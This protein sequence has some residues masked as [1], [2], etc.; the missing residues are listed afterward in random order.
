M[1]E[2]EKYHDT[3]LNAPECAVFQKLEEILGKPIP[4]VTQLKSQPESHSFGFVAGDGYAT[5]LGLQGQKLSVLPECIGN[6]VSLQY[7]GLSSNEISSLPQSMGQLKLL[8]KLELQEN[9]LISLPMSI[10]ELTSLRE[11]NL[12][13]NKLSSL[14]DSIGSL[15]SLKMLALENNQLLSLPET[16]GN[17]SSLKTL[18][19]SR[20]H[21]PSLPN[22]IGQLSSLE[23]LTLANNPLKILPDSLGKLQFLLTLDLRETLLSQLGFLPEKITQ[24]IEAIIERKIKMGQV[25]WCDYFYPGL[26]NVCIYICNYLKNLEKEGMED[27]Y[28][29]LAKILGM[30]WT[31]FMAEVHSWVER[32]HVQLDTSDTITFGKDTDWP[33]LQRVLEQIVFM[34]VQDRQTTEWGQKE[35][36]EGGK[37]KKVYDQTKKVNEPLALPLPRLELEALA[38]LEQVYGF[39]IPIVP[40]LK[41]GIDG[42]AVAGGCVIAISLAHAKLTTL[43][44]TFSNFTHL[45]TLNLSNSPFKIF[46]GTICQLKSLQDLILM[47]CGL[48]SLPEGIGNLKSLQTLELGVNN[49]ETLPVAIGQLGTLQYIDL[50]QNKFTSFPEAITR[51]SSLTRLHLG[52]N[53]LR[54]LPAS[55]ESL[56]SLLELDLYDNSFT[57]FPEIVIRLKSLRSLGI[58]GILFTDNP[59]ISPFVSK[60]EK[61]GVYVEDVDPLINEDSG[62]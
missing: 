22:G 2:I 59:V 30:N 38:D 61:A 28:A 25:D 36:A 55:L 51:L 40:Y 26:P 16:V 56:T 17:L 34:V 58:G 49:L 45:K 13:S 12:N 7:L 41:R 46:P 18:Y 20:N 5:A 8:E 57:N 62:D 6:L 48:E 4:N 37:T 53:K 32:F 10:G 15:I 50:H 3:P 33:G 24:V 19:L 60:L 52:G 43:P 21:L 1:V 23:T 39:H 29:A 54:S 11:L 47:G 27:F 31:T 14:P 9:H 35:M 42:I 44:K